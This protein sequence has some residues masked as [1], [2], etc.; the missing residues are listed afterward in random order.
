MFLV[1]CQVILG[2]VGE[3]LGDEAGKVQR[4]AE[5]SAKEKGR[6]GMVIC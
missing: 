3:I 6:I 1:A 4:G 5:C 2:M